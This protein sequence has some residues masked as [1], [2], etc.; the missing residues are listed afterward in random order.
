MNRKIFA[1]YVQEVVRLFE[2]K[3]NKFSSV[4]DA[5]NNFRNR[6]GLSDQQI[7]AIVKEAHHKVAYNIYPDQSQQT[8]SDPMEQKLAEE[9]IDNQKAIEFMAK[10]KNKHTKETG[11][12]FVIDKQKGNSIIENLDKNKSNPE[13]KQEDQTNSL[14]TDTVAMLRRLKKLAAEFGKVLPFPGQLPSKEMIPKLQQELE[15]L[16][17][18]TP[19]KI[20]RYGFEFTSLSD[21]PI[22]PNEPIKAKI[23]LYSFYKDKMVEQINKDLKEHLQK[24]LP[25]SQWIEYLK[26]GIASN[27]IPGEIGRHLVTK[28]EKIHR[29]L[30][31]EEKYEVDPTAKRQSE[32][33]KKL[34]QWFPASY[35][36]QII[37]MMASSQ[38]RN[39]EKFSTSYVA[40]QFVVMDSFAPFANIEFDKTDK[41]KLKQL[42]KYI[43][44]NDKFSFTNQQFKDLLSTLQI[45]YTLVPTSETLQSVTLHPKLKP[46]EIKTENSNYKPLTGADV[47][48]EKLHDHVMT[49]ALD[50]V[51]L[52]YLQHEDGSQ[53][54][55]SILDLGKQKIDFTKDK[56]TISADDKQYQVANPR[57][58]L[59][60][61]YVGD[62][63]TEKRIDRT[64]LPSKPKEQLDTK[65]MSE[66]ELIRSLI[67]NLKNQLTKVA[68]GKIY[69]DFE[70]N[71][72]SAEQQMKQQIFEKMWN[73]SKQ[74]VIDTVVK[75]NMVTP[76]PLALVA[77][78]KEQLKYVRGETK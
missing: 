57:K 33:I 3:S 16:E 21:G 8:S 56:I 10:S 22:R 4:E 29:Q 66:E 30:Y 23:Y 70:G 7:T 36:K 44:E 46:I 78:L 5:L 75:Q 65:P 49:A 27:D 51:P 69:I 63:P 15:T 61:S 42:V 77:A 64:R 45:Q 48:P 76:E 58:G 55:L 24:E 53:T 11:S 62:L 43:V 9:G 54:P 68:N 72:Y 52:A 74:E 60:Q 67:G 12:P 2:G 32:Q 18:D 13:I 28:L 6:L 26:A 59:H 37:Q 1:S 25:L 71:K 40:S 38:Y 19:F 50:D 17:L 35:Q 31:G 47:T 34:M 41:E 73:Q 20:S 14:S 39:M